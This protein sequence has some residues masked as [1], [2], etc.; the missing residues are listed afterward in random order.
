MGLPAIP[1][2]AELTPEKGSESV[3]G[4]AQRV[5]GAL[6]EPVG[7]LQAGRI[8]VDRQT[9][10]LGAAKTEIPLPAVGVHLGG[11]LGIQS[12]E[13]GSP[14]VGVGSPLA[15]HR[16]NRIVAAGTPSPAAG[17]HPQT[18]LH[19]VQTAVEVVVGTV[20]AVGTVAA[21]GI[22]VVVVAAHPG[23]SWDSS[24]LACPDA[25]WWKK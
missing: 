8:L 9:Q 17:V 6:V 10:S 19:L 24:R 5:P 21:V 25:V 22:A 11:P 16:E 4:R 3:A 12:V 13:V 18:Q 2:P 7:P 15:E 20:V 14:L 23:A 1:S